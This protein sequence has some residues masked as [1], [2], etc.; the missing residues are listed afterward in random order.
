[1]NRPWWQLRGAGCSA[2]WPGINANLGVFGGGGGIWRAS[3]GGW[4]GRWN[5]QGA[6]NAKF[7]VL[8]D[9]G[10]APLGGSA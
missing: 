2:E 9:G 1:M 3:R 5:R 4:R 6:K 10:E 8:S 7:G